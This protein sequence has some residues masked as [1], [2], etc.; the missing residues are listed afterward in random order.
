MGGFFRIPGVA[1]PV[2]LLCDGRNSFIT[3][4]S[5]MSVFTCSVF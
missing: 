2:E 5:D 1:I 3:T 4:D